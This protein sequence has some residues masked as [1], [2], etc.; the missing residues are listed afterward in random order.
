MAAVDLKLAR[1]FEADLGLGRDFTKGGATRLV[2][3]ESGMGW[4]G[5]VGA[6][7]WL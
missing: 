6:M 4:G 1:P 3:M 2:D 7:I 5:R